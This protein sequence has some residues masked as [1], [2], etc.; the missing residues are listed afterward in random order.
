MRKIILYKSSVCRPTSLIANT[1][2]KGQPWSRPK[3]SIGRIIHVSKVE[4][5]NCPVDFKSKLAQLFREIRMMHN[6][7]IAAGHTPLFPSARRTLRLAV[8]PVAAVLL[9]VMVMLGSVASAQPAKE[10]RVGDQDVSELIL[11]YDDKTSVDRATSDEILDAI[12]N[13][14]RS[15]RNGFLNRALNSPK[16]GRYA[17]THRHNYDVS[18]L[19]LL[20]Y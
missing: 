2:S 7:N 14:G 9:L 17:I 1:A 8:S 16:S 5:S 19:V 10:K 18:L 12:R 15:S 13:P 6:A 4:L 3:C 20:C 11:L